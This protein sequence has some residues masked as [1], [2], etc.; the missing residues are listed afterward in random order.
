[1]KESITNELE[2]HLNKLKINRESDN[3]E[4]DKKFYFNI[5]KSPNKIEEIKDELNMDFPND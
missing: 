3:K 2:E 1:M 5:E 4:D